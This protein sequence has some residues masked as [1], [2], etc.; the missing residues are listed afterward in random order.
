MPAVV[1]APVGA[2]M[3]LSYRVD[4]SPDTL[5]NRLIASYGYG[6]S[7]RIWVAGAF[8]RRL[9]SKKLPT[10]RTKHRLQQDAEGSPLRPQFEFS[11]I[12]DHVDLQFENHGS[13]P[14]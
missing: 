14:A 9:R 1:L 13:I 2:K 3:V 12:S 5:S 8:R 11:G 4:R 6:R 7:A 10:L